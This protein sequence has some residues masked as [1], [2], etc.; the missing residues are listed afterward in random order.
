[1]TLPDIRLKDS[2]TDVN[3]LM[4]TYSS[5]ADYETFLVG[6][7]TAETMMRD[8]ETGDLGAYGVG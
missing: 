6:G 5:A 2:A 4:P 8:I 3:R 1:M 7:Q